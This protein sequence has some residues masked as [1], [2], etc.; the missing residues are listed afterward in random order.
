MTKVDTHNKVSPRNEQSM[1][2]RD[3]HHGRLAYKKPS[4]EEKRIRVHGPLSC[5][6]FDP[7]DE[8]LH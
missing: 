1:Y 7:H 2:H 4:N 8:E 6:E 5:P 3:Y